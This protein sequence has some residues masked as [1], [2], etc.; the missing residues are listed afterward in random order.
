[1]RP[2]RGRRRWTSHEPSA[3]FEDYE[4]KLRPLVDGETVL[5]GNA[6]PIAVEG[7]GA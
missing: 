1:V 5:F 7:Y 3:R 2:G 6:A 4:S